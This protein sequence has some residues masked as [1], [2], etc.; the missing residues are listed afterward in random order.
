[1]PLKHISSNWAVQ[2]KYYFNFN[3]KFLSETLA[4]PLFGGLN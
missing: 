3:L 1:M 4:R 2:E